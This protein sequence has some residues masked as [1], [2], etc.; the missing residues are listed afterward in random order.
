MSNEQLIET[1]I[2][3]VLL[4]YD[5]ICAVMVFDEVKCYRAEHARALKTIG[6]ILL[7]N[8]IVIIYKLTKGA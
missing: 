3:V 1:V 8:A 4:T 5:L 6:V 2:G 7:I